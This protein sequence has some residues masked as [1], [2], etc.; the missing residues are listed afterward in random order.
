MSHTQP[1][2]L[3]AHTMQW[4]DDFVQNFD[5]QFQHQID[6]YYKIVASENYTLDAVRS[7]RILIGKQKLGRTF[8]SDKI[9]GIDF[10]KI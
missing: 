4:V 3:S 8:N 10:T 7:S 2:L 5:T 1:V 9:G 6:N